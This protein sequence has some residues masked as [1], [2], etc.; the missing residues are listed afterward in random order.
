MS[1]INIPIHLFVS[2]SFNDSVSSRMVISQR[3]SIVDVVSEGYVSFTLIKF[4]NGLDLFE[5]LV[6]FWG[7]LSAF[8]SGKEESSEKENQEHACIEA[9]E[10]SKLLR[11]HH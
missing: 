11:F 4:A 9:Y 5:R 7:D 10:E 2:D 8:H 1:S 6:V 3:F